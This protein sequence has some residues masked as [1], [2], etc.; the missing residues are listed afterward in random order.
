MKKISKNPRHSNSV[1]IYKFKVPANKKDALKLGIIIGLKEAFNQ[2]INFP[3]EKLFI[4][5]DYIKNLFRRNQLSDSISINYLINV[6][7]SDTKITNAFEIGKLYGYRK[8]IK[9]LLLYKG[10]FA[11]N[12]REL[13][14]KIKFVDI[15]YE[16]YQ[17]DYSLPSDKLLELL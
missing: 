4:E 15:L 12:Q 6:A 17:F 2:L 8:G 14:E 11:S 16:K 7:S 3:I 9:E 13:S 10:N 5:F 1:P